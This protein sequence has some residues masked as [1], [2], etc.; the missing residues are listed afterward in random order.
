MSARMR[1]ITDNYI[2][3]P[4]TK[5]R[6][7][8]VDFRLEVIKRFKDY[9]MVFDLLCFEIANGKPKKEYDAVVWDDTSV[10]FIE[11]KSPTTYK[12]LKAKKAQ[13]WE[14]TAKNIAKELGFKKYGAIIVVRDENEKVAIERSK[15]GLNV[16]PLSE[17]ANFD[18]GKAL[19]DLTS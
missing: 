12:T 6:D 4:K 17:L 5:P 15:P 13:S 2:L 1:F 8:E 9:A 7:D 19:K 11:F 16:I 18:L 3:K 10:L 14:A